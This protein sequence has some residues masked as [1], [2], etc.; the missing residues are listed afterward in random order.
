MPD[1]EIVNKVINALS[2]RG[3]DVTEERFEEMI[4]SDFDRYD[5]VFKALA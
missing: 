2:Y 4:N 5:K 1:D 3:K